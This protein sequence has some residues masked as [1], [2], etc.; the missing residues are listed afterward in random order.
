MRSLRRAAGIK[1][2]AADECPGRCAVAEIGPVRLRENAARV[3]AMPR[4]GS[5]APA[6]PH[7]RLSDLA[8]RTTPECV[9]IQL[10]FCA[11]RCLIS[12]N[13]EM[14]KYG[15]FQDILTGCTGLEPVTSCL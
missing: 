12:H 14:P 4:M 10:L 15:L 13:R 6:R 7:D 8:S 9:A 11:S 5:P 1:G 2:V 3:I